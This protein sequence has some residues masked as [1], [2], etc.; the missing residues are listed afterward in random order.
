MTLPEFSIRRHVMALMMSAILVLFGIIG[1][2]E[3]GNDRLPDIDFPIISIQTALPGA[4]PN[5]VEASVTQFI[6]RAVNTVPGIDNVT[7]NSSP[8]ISVVN[9]TFDLD[10][11]IDVA[12]SEVQTR[13]SEEIANLPEDAEA[14][15]INKVE[16]DAQPVMWLSVQGDRDAQQL[17][18]IARNTVRPLL[19]Q[20]PGVG[21]VQVGG[22][23]ERRVRIE[24]DAD[25]M[26]R[27]QLTVQE[28]MAAVESEHVI[29][30]GGFLVGGR[31]ERMVDLDL[32]YHDTD[33]LNNLIVLEMDGRLVRLGDVSDIVDGLEDFRQLARFR[34]EPTVGLGVVKIAG[35]NTVAIVEEV[36]NRLETEIR[37]M[38]PAGVEV[39]VASDQSVFINNLIDNL[40]N[41]L[42][43]AVL[44]AA[45]VMWLFLKSL[46]S[47]LIISAA[48]PVSLLSV[49][50]VMFFA[51]YTLNA[52]TM[53]AILLLIGLVVDDA[54]VVLEN[55]WRY[56]EKGESDPF[57]AAGDGA[58]EVYTPVIASS[59]SLIA[60]FGSVLFMEGI[61]GRFFE[62]FAVVVVFGVATSTFVALTLIPMLCSRFLQLPK[63][64]GR[65]SRYIET[66]F[67]WLDDHYRDLLSWVLTLRVKALLACGLLFIASFWLLGQLGGEFAPEEDEG[68]FVVSMR[69]P[70]GV[71]IHYMNEKLAEVE[72]ILGEQEEIDTYFAAIGLGTG[73]VNEAIAFVRL[74]PWGD[75][76]A[77]QREIMTRLNQAFTDLTGIRVFTA[78]PGLVG[79]QRG[80]PLQFH[81]RGPDLDELSNVA[82]EFMERLSAEEGM[83]EIDM[84]LRLEQPDLQLIVDR[85]RA[86]LM[87][88][89]TNDIVQA[90]S[91]FIGGLDI[92][93]YD[94]DFGDGERV[95]IRLKGR[96]DQF[97]TPEDIQRIWA[98]NADGERL[99]LDSVAHFEEGHSP[100]V[101]TRF[102]LQYSAPFFITPEMSLADAV[103]FVRAQANEVLPGGF[104]ISLVGEAEEF[105]RTVQ[106]VI[107][108]FVVSTLLVYMVLAS[109]FNSFLQP[110]IIMLA[111]PL[112]IMGAVLGLWL[113]GNNLNIFSMIGMVLLIGVVTKNSILLIDLTNQYRLKQNLGINEALKAACPIRLRPVLMTSLT[114][115]LA[116][117]PA[118]LDTGPGGQGNTALG[119]TIIFGMTIST[120]LTLLIVPCAYSLLEG[121]KNKI[122]VK[123]SQHQRA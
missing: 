120:A 109:Q 28:V 29:A 97:N 104:S 62:S 15:I 90:V 56:R 53:L 73:E 50:A 11:D 98:R 31:Q 49:I 30:P 3:I 112:A 66:A 8:G 7:S 75:R 36:R 106:A 89:N 108:V 84:E 99:R 34:G 40:E 46:R 122:A 70:L 19:E 69:A 85:E 91:V 78:S 113:T 17:T 64:Q 2:N 10:K 16:A 57:Q 105:E 26:S 9:V 41:T 45:L 14:P 35:A 37:P 74:K 81:V 76:D 116:M 48:I 72:H 6:E 60:I 107:F 115:I 1:Y 95:R 23:R 43:L 77:T 92:A 5:T 12:F 71:S 65:V 100:A 103:D 47:T 118:A 110:F 59:L 20:I 79:G 27:E 101:I 33:E 121:A 32:E 61:I 55:I 18:D 25:A 80:E 39:N 117:V 83:G 87:G 68:Q 111:M 93:R 42:L 123:K 86:R 102:D 38:L 88:L 82:D 94:D 58:N 67:Q 51:G 52:M 21:E 96:E 119:V 24:L 63:K 44:L 54:I 4:D 22:G 13:V 114:L